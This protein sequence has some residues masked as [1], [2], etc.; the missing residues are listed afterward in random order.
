MEK[1]VHNIPEKVLVDHYDL[2]VILF[3]VKQLG[4]F[5]STCE[6][7]FKFNLSTLQH[8]ILGHICCKECHV[9]HYCSKKCHQYKQLFKSKETYAA[10]KTITDK[11]AEWKWQILQKISLPITARLKILSIRGKYDPQICAKCELYKECGSKYGQYTGC[12]ITKY[13]SKKCQKQ[14]WMKHK[15]VCP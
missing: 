4:A 9:F 1:K 3:L 11:K 5:C 8:E 7:E 14:H 10:C 2:Q 12:Q 6:K 15:S 13:C